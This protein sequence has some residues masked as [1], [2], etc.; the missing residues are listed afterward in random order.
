[1]DLEPTVQTLLAMLKRPHKV[2]IKLRFTPPSCC[3]FPDA[4]I[5]FRR[6]KLF[7]PEICRYRTGLGV[8][9]GLGIW[10]GSGT[11][12]TNKSPLCRLWAYSKFIWNVSISQVSYGHFVHF[13][14][15]FKKSR[16]TVAIF[17]TIRYRSIRIG[18][19]LMDPDRDLSIITDLDRSGNISIHGRYQLFWSIFVDPD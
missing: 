15:V 9:Y 12:I 6:I 2:R 7:G 18:Q 14:F 4:D 1:M 5:S 8:R 19:R 17:F 16:D 10:Y 11:F 13:H 3:E